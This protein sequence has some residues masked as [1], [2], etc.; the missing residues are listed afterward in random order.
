MYATVLM[1]TRFPKSVRA[2]IFDVAAEEPEP[3]FFFEGNLLPP[4][5]TYQIQMLIAMEQ[6]RLQKEVLRV[7]KQIVFHKRR[8]EKWYTVFL[9]IFILLSCIEMLHYNQTSYLHHKRQNSETNRENVSYVTRHMLG[10]WENSAENLISHFRFVMN[11]N[12]LFSQQGASFQKNLAKASSF[13]D[14][15]AVS[16]IMVMRGELQRRMGELDQA[17]RSR[18]E[19]GERL[20]LWAVCELF[21]PDEEDM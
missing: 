7:L 21:L 14:Q 8:Q 11:G 16:Y 5:L 2:N 19:D 10:E 3:P 20:D 13:M 15:G 17:R 1:N 4:Q 9:V 6:D 12:M 18:Q